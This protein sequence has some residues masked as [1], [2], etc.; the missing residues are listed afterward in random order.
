MSLISP[1]EHAHKQQFRG[2][3]HTHSTL[4][5]GIY[6]MQEVIDLYGDRNF[7]FLMLS[8]HDTLSD[9]ADYDDRGMIL[10]PGNEITAQGGHLLHVNAKE[11]IQPDPDRQ[12]VLD[13]IERSGGF[14]II[15]HPN[16]GCRFSHWP[17]KEL[18]R[19]QGYRGI[20]IY[21]GVTERAE[22]EAQATD[23]W[24]MLL[25]QGRKIWG[26]GNDDFHILCDLERVW[27]M[28]FAE[29][30][31]AEALLESLE[32]GNFYVST[33]LRLDTITVCGNRVSISAPEVEC[34]RIIGDWGAIF[35]TVEGPELSFEADP[36]LPFSYF[37][38]ECFGK[39]TEKAWTQP[40]WL[41][42][43]H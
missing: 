4:T 38:I 37:R 40:F 27:N 22:G 39:G 14:A 36:E 19:L 21:N 24:D 32:R 35:A 33:G 26:Y 12:V 41:Q 7:D 8:D 17:Q 10:F 23:R 1:Y 15:N 9:P 29:S 11:L 6:S 43:P 30:R 34:Y 28:V 31:S 18:E 20:E 3:L 42:A 13:A 25:T 16:W 5:D 2:N